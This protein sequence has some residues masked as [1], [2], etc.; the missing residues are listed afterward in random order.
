[1][2][3]ALGREIGIDEVMAKLDRLQATVASLAVDNRPEWYTIRQVAEKRGKHIR[4]IQRKI[5]KGEIGVKP[6]ST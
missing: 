6:T 5:A 3:S 1:M 2:T 4:T